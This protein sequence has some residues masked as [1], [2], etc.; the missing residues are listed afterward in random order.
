MCFLSLQPLL[1][2]CSHMGFK[3][4]MRAGAAIVQKHWRGNTHT[5]TY[6]QT[7]NMPYPA[8]KCPLSPRSSAASLL[9]VQQL[10]TYRQ[11]NSEPDFQIVLIDCLHCLM[12][13]TCSLQPAGVWNHA[14]INGQAARGG[15]G[16]GLSKTVLFNC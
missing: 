15:K 13:S 6:T 3:H 16:K 12:Y 2:P 7:N 14:V 1:C 9:C 4:R 11:P 8:L 10:H 5:Y